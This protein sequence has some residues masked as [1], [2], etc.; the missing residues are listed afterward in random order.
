MRC[1]STIEAFDVETWSPNKS[2]RAAKTRLA[3]ME[4]G[5][6]SPTLRGT[7]G[8]SGEGH[9][10]QS[11]EEPGKSARSARHVAMTTGA[12]GLDDPNAGTAYDDYLGS[13]MV[14]EPEEVNIFADSLIWLALASLAPSQTLLD[15]YVR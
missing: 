15:M 1:N 13:L 14:E 10:R 5:I 9:S 6:T 12:F 4:S 11:R 3:K 7:S 2:L 8:R